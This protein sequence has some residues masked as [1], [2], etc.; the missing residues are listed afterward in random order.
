VPEMQESGQPETSSEAKPEER[1]NG[2]TRDFTTGSAE[3]CEIRVAGDAKALRGLVKA[4]VERVNRSLPP[5]K[6]ISDF[7]L[8]A[9]EFEKTSSR[10]IKRYLYKTWAEAT[11]EKPSP[12]A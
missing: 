2:A 11:G 3:G 5:Y 1:T 7:H 4:E 12:G 6:K 8:R 10:K 9:Q